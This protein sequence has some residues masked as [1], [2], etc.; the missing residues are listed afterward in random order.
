MSPEAEQRERDRMAA[1]L[2]ILLN[3]AEHY[4]HTS[5]LTLVPEEPPQLT[6]RDKPI[7]EAWARQVA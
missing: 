4:D 2:N 3:L 7:F 5:A 6:D 1:A